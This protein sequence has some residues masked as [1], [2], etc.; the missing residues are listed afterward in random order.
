MGSSATQDLNK[1]ESLP[2]SDKNG[3]TNTSVG[4]RPLVEAVSSPFPTPPLFDY[5]DAAKASHILNEAK[6][7]QFQGQTL[8]YHQ[9]Q[10]HLLMIH[11]LT[12]HLT[13][14]IHSNKL[15]LLTFQTNHWLW[16]AI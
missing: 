12:L 13:F 6:V 2:S 11:W 1:E 10:P 15:K 7:C 3:P 16:V 14:Y 9:R 4:G 8:S 5:N